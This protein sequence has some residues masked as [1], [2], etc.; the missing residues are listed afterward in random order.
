MEREPGLESG[1]LAPSTILP[2][3]HW[4]ASH[5]PLPCARPLF[6]HLMNEVIGLTISEDFFNSNSLVKT[7]DYAKDFPFWKCWTELINAIFRVGQVSSEQTPFGWELSHSQ[8]PQERVLWHPC[9]NQ[10][11][12][13]SWPQLI[14]P[15]VN[16]TLN[17]PIRLSFPEIGVVSCAHL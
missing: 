9:F 5:N 12:R 13:T 3:T 11:N 4:Q 7:H 14:G 8:H 17:V 10:V 15:E 2:L 1:N 16:L 6:S